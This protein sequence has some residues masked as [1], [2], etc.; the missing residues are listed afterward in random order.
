MGIETI[1]EKSEAL[2]LLVEAKR[3][4]TLVSNAIEDQ[5]DIK[6]TVRNKDFIIALQK[7]KIK[8]LEG[9]ILNG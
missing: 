5:D 6:A 7:R 2:E 4:S 8:T 3:L 1:N 9:V